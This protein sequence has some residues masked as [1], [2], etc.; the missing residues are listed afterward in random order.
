VSYYLIL[1]N[2]T[3]QGLKNLKNCIQSIEIFRGYI[4]R[5]GNPYHDTFYSFGHYD[6]VSLVEADNDNDVRFSLL[7]AEKQGN[8]SSTTLKSITHKEAIQL[9]ESVE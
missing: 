5:M 9:A 6:A 2:F 7:Q 8:L 4:E 3:E 1:W